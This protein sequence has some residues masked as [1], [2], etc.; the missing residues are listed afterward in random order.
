MQAGCDFIFHKASLYL[1][2]TYL[3]IKALLL[4]KWV[5]VEAVLGHLVPCRHL[6][7]TGCSPDKAG[8]KKLAAEDLALRMDKQPWEVG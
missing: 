6:L 4:C 8:W 7:S 2:V 3:L 1:T 5:L